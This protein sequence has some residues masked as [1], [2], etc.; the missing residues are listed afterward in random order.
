[1]PK[2]QSA[3]P[4]PKPAKA[5]KPTSEIRY[6]NDEDDLMERLARLCVA[7]ADE[8]HR[9]RVEA[10]KESVADENQN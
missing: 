9:Q 4:K 2:K 3:P 10:Q 8:K 7:Y 5:A 1:M 6:W